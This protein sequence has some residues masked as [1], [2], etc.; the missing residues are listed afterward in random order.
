MF[1]DDILVYSPSETNHV[2]YLE[3]V[4]E[5]LSMNQLYVNYKK[6]EFGKSEVAYLGYVVSEKGVAADFS[7]IQ[8]MWEWPQPCNIRELRGFL[9]LTGYYRKVI[10]GYAQIAYPLT[11]QLKKDS[12]TWTEEAGS[13]WSF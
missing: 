11:E 13:Y 2:K 8:A 1:F 3:L 10:V 12:F 5:T 6:C 7:K 9:G 4:L